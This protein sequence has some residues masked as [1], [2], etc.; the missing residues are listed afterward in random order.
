MCLEKI[1]FPKLRSVK[2]HLSERKIFTPMLKSPPA[3][4]NYE[5]MHKMGI[6]KHDNSNSLMGQL[7][8]ATECCQIVRYLTLQ[9]PGGDSTDWCIKQCTVSEMQPAPDLQCLIIEQQPRVGALRQRQPAGPSSLRDDDG[10]CLECVM[11]LVVWHYS[12][13]RMIQSQRQLG[14]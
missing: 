14:V 8:L 1:R 6:W 2:Q 3:D 12:V 9:T 4:A 5:E 10:S 7:L 11:F 13:N